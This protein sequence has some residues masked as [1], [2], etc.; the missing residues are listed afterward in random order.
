[1]RNRQIPSLALFAA[2]AASP[3]FAQQ[4][5]PDNQIMGDVKSVFTN[6]TV[7]QGKGMSINPTVH[8]GIVSLNGTVTSDAAKILASNEIAQIPGI[9]TVLNNLTVVDPNAS[10]SRTAAP[11]APAPSADRVR[12]IEL[13]AHTTIPI[14]IREPLNTK[15]VKVGDTFHGTVASAVYQTGFPMIPAGTPVMGRVSEAKPAGR[16][17]GFA[18]LTLEL[19]AIRLTV[20]DGADQTVSLVTLPLS[21]KTNGRGANTAV[22]GAGGAGLGAIIG[23]MAGGGT[24]AAIGAVSGGALGTGANALMPGQ[25]IELQSESLLQFVTADPISIAVKLHNGLPVTHPPAS[26]EAVLTARNPVPQPQTTTPQ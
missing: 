1:M 25:Q 13:H 26:G 16:L 4:P 21:S 3:L 19:T 10:P 6:E 8:G 9:K 18:L 20:P 5:R 17:V 22:K 15:T 12:T 14:R 23:A 7:F 11:I 24:G 2:L